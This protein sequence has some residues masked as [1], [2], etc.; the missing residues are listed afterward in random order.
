MHARV[1]IL[2]GDPDQIEHGLRYFREEVQQEWET[3]PGF[4]GAVSR[5][6]RHNGRTISIAFWESKEHLHDEREDHNRVLSK[7]TEPAGR[8]LVGIEWYEVGLFELN[9]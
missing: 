1:T 8:E 2:E 9:L 3:H 5:H 4:K 6:D 7:V